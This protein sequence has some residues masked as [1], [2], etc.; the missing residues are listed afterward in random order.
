M[1]YLDEN[2]NEIAPAAGGGKRYLNDQ[3]EPVR[4]ES[5]P[6]VLAQIQSTVVGRRK[7]AEQAAQAIATREEPTTYDA[8]M[9]TMLPRSYAAQDAGIEPD[10]WTRLKDSWSLPMRGASGLSSGL[11]TGVGTLAGGGSLDDALSAG[12][13]A[14]REDMASPGATSDRGA[15]GGFASN[16]L[17]DPMLPPMVA[18]GRF[19]ATGWTGLGA[20]MAEGSGMMLARDVADAGSSWEPESVT[21][22]Q[23]ALAMAAGI[24][25][26]GIAG[27]GSKLLALPAKA[28]AEVVPKWTAL[29]KALPGA[30]NRTV[31]EGLKDFA[32]AGPGDRVDLRQVLEGGEGIGPKARDVAGIAANFRKLR[33]DL[34]SARAGGT[35]ARMDA[36]GQKVDVRKALKAGQESVWGMQEGAEN[37]A[38]RHAAVS[39]LEQTLLVP[40]SGTR[41][42][43]SD[44]K[45]PGMAFEEPV[46]PGQ[47]PLNISEEWIPSTAQWVK[48]LLN[49]RVK[50]GQPGESAY[51]AAAEG[52]GRNIK[53]QLEAIASA[54][55]D[56]LA[57]ENAKIGKYLAADLGV[58]RAE[59]RAANRDFFSLLDLASPRK[60]LGHFASTREAPAGLLRALDAER[61]LPVTS[62]IQ[63]SGALPYARLLSKGLFYGTTQKD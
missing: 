62:V 15:V 57:R 32:G 37:M 36:T 48:T 56:D 41:P 45:F 60:I 17:K 21:P 16:M 25:P 27:A 9:K 55:G 4:I 58:M 1:A 54:S 51:E 22:G 35:T 39:D 2:G 28:S 49:K 63:N 43:Y 47:I 30:K 33:D 38:H 40:P 61:Y 42:I 19:P 34:I 46:M 14:G 7:N 6:G 20:R 31:W 59:S 13:A 12:M 3:G 52:A 5:A 50:F 53:E 18:L 44:P 26:E 29:M 11:A 8:V 24:I 23:I 10:Y